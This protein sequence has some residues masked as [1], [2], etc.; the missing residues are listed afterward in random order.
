MNTLTSKIETISA[1]IDQYSDYNV[2]DLLDLDHVK[3]IEQLISV[4][5]ADVKFSLIGVTKV[6]LESNK[7]HFNFNENIDSD[8]VINLITKDKVLVAEKFDG[9]ATFKFNPDFTEDAKQ[10]RGSLVLMAALYEV[11]G[12]TVTYA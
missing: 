12:H 7:I 4:F 11:C 3:D 9:G 5:E 1:R 10:I 8:V 2:A 6:Q